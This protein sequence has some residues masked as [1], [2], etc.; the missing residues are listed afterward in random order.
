MRCAG[1]LA[2][3]AATGA[4]VRR[5]G[6][7][8]RVAEVYPAAALRIWQLPTAGYKTEPS[9]RSRSG[10]SALA[11]QAPWL[12]WGG[13]RGMCR[14]RRRPGR[15]RLRVVAGAVVVGRTARPA[16]PEE[17]LAREE[18]WI[19][20][21]DPEFSWR[22]SS[23]S[24]LGDCGRRRSVGL[25]TTHVVDED[26]T[27]RSAHANSAA[28]EQVRSRGR[29]C[30]IA[31]VLAGCAAAQGGAAVPASGHRLRIT[32]LRHRH[33]ITGR[34]DEPSSRT[35]AGDRRSARPPRGRPISPRTA[36]SAVIETGARNPLAH[37]RSHRRAGQREGLFRA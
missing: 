24:E 13:Q 37:R 7:D 16:P 10:E 34:F 31:A 27:Y 4:P 6:I 22:P 28:L 2:R 32:E 18:G 21:P 25:W 1:L 15:R 30:R 33:C 11:A 29:A 23:R 20:L 26:F 36:W 19:H 5:D 14:L 12:D 17:A 3:I 9:V 8:S 35:S